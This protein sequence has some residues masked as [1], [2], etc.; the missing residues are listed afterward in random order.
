MAMADDFQ[1]ISSLRYDPTLVQVP[2]AGLR[3]AGWNWAKASLLYL[4]DYHR[5]R[6]LR[7]AT[8]FGWDAAVEILSGEAG[9]RRLR[10]RIMA[11]V[12]E[13][14]RSSMKVRVSITRQGE[15]G[16]STTPV[17]GTPF[18]N[19]FPERLPPP[20]WAAESKPGS[21]IP[22]KDPVYEILVDDLKAT[23]SEHTHFKTTKRD[24]YNR[25]RQR[26]QLGLHDRKEVLLVSDAEGAVMEASTSTPYFW[27]GGRWVTP[28]VSPE[29]SLG[30]GSG[31]QAG[32]S[33][34]WALERY[35]NGT[36]RT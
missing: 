27:R 19:L 29:Y 15:L 2:T 35:G 18:A 20:E 25:A 22:S 4:L 16:I 10:D 11:S 8:H 32:T 34:R 17:P 1:L 6:M 7:A 9:L 14:Q 24:V 26:A 30:T 5:D 3:H 23:C 21:H 36:F 28:P 33:R 13:D 12:G 31:G